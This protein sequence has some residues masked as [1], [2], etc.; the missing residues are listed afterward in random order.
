M[1]EVADWVG[2]G[3][4]LVMI[5]HTGQVVPA[6]ISTDL[7]HALQEARHGVREA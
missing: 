1:K 3:L 2:D 6:P 7:Y 4:R 5:V